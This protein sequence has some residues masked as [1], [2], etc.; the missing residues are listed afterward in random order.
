MCA[1][2]CVCHHAYVKVATFGKCIAS[3][4]QLPGT[5]G[6]SAALDA[7]RMF[8]TAPGGTFDLRPAM[9]PP[10]K[11]TAKKRP[12]QMPDEP[13]DGMWLKRVPSA[14]KAPQFNALFNASKRK[15]GSYDSC[16]GRSVKQ[17]TGL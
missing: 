2:L 5:L 15:R 7:Y 1:C 14:A 9:Q 10:V 3:Q 12:L 17:R 8:N 11:K 16:Q 13:I 4:S 6:T